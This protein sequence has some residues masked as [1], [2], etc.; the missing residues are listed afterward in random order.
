MK[1]A[2]SI[3]DLIGHTPLLELTHYE[4]AHALRATVLAKLECMNPAGSAKDRVA[5]HMI[6]KA[7]EQG[8]LAPGGTIIEPTS[9]NTGIGLAAMGAAKGYH[10]ILTMPDTMS[11][12]RQKLIAAYGAEIVLTPGAAG[13]AGAVEKVE[14]L[15]R[16]IPGSIVAGQFDNPA[17]PEAHV[18]TT[19]PEIW[20]DTEGRVDIFVA[21]I[22]TG[23]TISGTGG[24]LKGQNPA[25]QVVG[26]E[27][28]ASPLLTAGHAGPHGLQGIGANFVPKNF[29]RSVV[30]EIIPVTDEDAYAAG[31][32]L[33]QREG[34]LVGI[35]SGA[36]VWA[37]AQLAMR[38]ENRGKVIVVLLPDT[39]ERYLS[40]PMFQ[41]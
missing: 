37:A 29:C 19:G 24:Y 32:E 27:P 38:P 36:A 28:A 17:N 26:V 34:V 31:R 20:A 41:K 40:T 18:L 13:M 33:A 14:A 11:V 1:I 3:Q 10:V 4:A 23:G 16:E 39:G 35:T 15:R 9:G 22:G 8:R 7:E 12:E 5:A 21:G 2:H 25:V 6:E 30:D